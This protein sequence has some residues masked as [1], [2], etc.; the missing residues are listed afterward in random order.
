MQKLLARDLERF[1]ELLE[2]CLKS[3]PALMGDIGLDLIKAGG[4]RIRPRL[5]L[6]SAHLLGTDTHNGQTV[7]LAVEMLHTASLLHDDLI[8][9]AETRRGKVAAYKQFGNTMSVMAGDF[10]LAKVLRLLA[11]SANHDFTMLMSDAAAA[12]VAAEVRQFELSQADGTPDFESYLQVIDGKTAVLISAA[13]EGVAIL[14]GSPAH[15]RQALR[16]FGLAYGRAFQLQDDYLDLLGDEQQLGKPVGSDLSEGKV[17][18][19]VLVLLEQG[20]SEAAAI[21]ARRADQPGDA[22]RMAQLVRESGAAAATSARIRAE[23]DRAVAALAGFPDSEAKTA[24]VELVS[25]E[26]ERLA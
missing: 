21:V 5:A 14:A 19:P 7:A 22:Q 9:D 25:T 12:I 13:L 6:L 10:L 18:W 20:N 26:T 17:T 16:T 23:S 2:A 15:E 8:D 1:D 3:D 24:L 11:G 4:K